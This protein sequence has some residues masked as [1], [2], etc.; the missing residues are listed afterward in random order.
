MSGDIS[1]KLDARTVSG[2]KVANLRRD[3]LVPSVVYG[4]TADAI[5]TQSQMVETIKVAHAAGKHTPVH[6]TIDGKKQLAI[7]KSLDFDPVKHLLRHVSFQAIKQN[8]IIET[9]VPIRL[10]GLGE[11]LAERAGLVILQA[12]EH[13]EV[14]AKPANLPEALELSVLELSSTEDKL[15]IG[16][17]KLP[18]GV[19]FADNDQDIDL[20]VANVYE[21]AALQAANEAAG[22]D[23]EEVAEVESENGG[24]TPQDAQ[25]GENMPGGKNQDEPKQSNVD[26]N[27]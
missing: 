1:L 19:E 23:A 21:T 8:E 24:D 10:I 3:G 2:K 20:V 5:S 7:I 18:E 14:K 22:G 4:G 26:A 27:K 12:I 15:T 11:S 13:I 9:Q 6:L 17:I 16:D 25:A